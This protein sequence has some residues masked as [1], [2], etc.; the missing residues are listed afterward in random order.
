[1]NKTEIIRKHFEEEARE[2]D[3]IILKIIPYYK[4]MVKA[5]ILSLPFGGSDALKVMDLGCGTGTLAK[6]VKD[7]FPN[8]TI[9]C[10]DLS[11][12]MLH[13]AKAKLADCSGVSFIACDFNAYDFG[14]GYDVIVS[15]LALHHLVTDEEKRKFYGR[16]YDSLS[17][18]GVFCNADVVLGSSDYLQQRYIGK[19]K[20]FINRSV[21][22]E[23]TENKWMVNYKREDSPSV[24]MRQLGWL[25][26]IGFK[27]VDVIWKYYNF[28]VYGGQK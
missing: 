22:P 16:I 24:L 18:G 6:E 10:I 15:S 8:A 13:M 19:W 11:E 4:E 28:S 17:D 2:Y 9:D 25:G 5:L 3:E 12:N 1:M 7:A 21:S 27:N 26:D 14:G 23:E 20:E